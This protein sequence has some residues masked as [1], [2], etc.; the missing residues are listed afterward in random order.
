MKKEIRFISVELAVET[1]KSHLPAALKIMGAHAKNLMWKLSASE[2]NS[3]AKNKEK[4]LKVSITPANKFSPSE[5][6][7]NFS[8]INSSAISI[9]NRLLYNWC[10][11][12]SEIFPPNWWLAE[13]MAGR[14]IIQISAQDGI[15]N[16]QCDL[17]NFIKLSLE[18]PKLFKSIFFGININDW[19]RQLE[20]NKNKGYKSGGEP[21]VGAMDALEEH[22]LFV[23]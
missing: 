5:L 20:K 1:T 3:T 11:I 7:S 14:K 2:T 16:I 15:I 21:A 12:S 6:G 17:R 19:Y 8:E 18:N 13:D 23:R 4:V 9:L 22:G 10:D